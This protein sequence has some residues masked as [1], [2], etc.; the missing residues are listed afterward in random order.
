MKTPSLVF[1]PDFFP[2]C[3]PILDIWSFIRTRRRTRLRTD[4]ETV[5]A[6]HVK[7]RN[8]THT[9]H[10][11]TTHWYTLWETLE[12]A[13]KY[14][15]GHVQEHALKDELGHTQ[16]ILGFAQHILGHAQVHVTKHALGVA[17]EH[18]MKHALGHAQ[19][20]IMKD[21]LGHAQEIT[22]EHVQRNVLKHEHV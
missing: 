10:D 18:V 8:G 16:H 15:L 21:K 2:G 17:Q 14:A 3:F 6:I 13:L 11:Q 22:L 5:S 4:T 20:H 1:S 12:V 7:T 9:R 19:E